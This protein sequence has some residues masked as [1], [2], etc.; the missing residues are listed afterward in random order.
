MKNLREKPIPDRMYKVQCHGINI[1][2]TKRLKMKSI[3]TGVRLT[4][5]SVPSNLYQC[6]LTRFSVI[7]KKFV[8]VL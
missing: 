6:Q 4:T 5:A 3:A 2:Q 8:L 1:F 7:M